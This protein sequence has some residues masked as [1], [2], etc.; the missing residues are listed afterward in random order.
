VCT[1]ARRTHTLFFHGK[2][3]YVWQ[4]GI[5]RTGSY[6]ELTMANWH[7]AK[8]H[9]VKHQKG[10]LGALSLSRISFYEIESIGGVRRNG[11]RKM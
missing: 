6:G 10:T 4:I 8:R 1:R 11:R 9:M 7:M 3:A 2:L 5:W